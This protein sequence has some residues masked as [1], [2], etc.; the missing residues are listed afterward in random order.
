MAN[1]SM[2]RKQGPGHGLN[3]DQ[4]AELKEAF[5]LF[6]KDGDGNIPPQELGAIMMS[7]GYDPT[8]QE[9]EVMINDANTSGSGALDFVEFLNFMGKMFKK[10][11]KNDVV[12][13]SFKA[14]DPSNKGYI[15]ANEL[16]DMLNRVGEKITEAEVHEMIK[17]ADADGDGRINFDDFVR[18]MKSD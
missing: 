10:L 1:A 14:F 15:G 12:G 11:D 4:I 13:S 7:L 5:S 18:L 8:P 6:D 9:L 17:H 2:F 3:D 16:M